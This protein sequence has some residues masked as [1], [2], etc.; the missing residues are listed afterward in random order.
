MVKRVH[1][2]KTREKEN[3]KRKRN[4]TGKKMGNQSI[5]KQKKKLM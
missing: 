1:Y 5:A 2:F 3:K 4:K